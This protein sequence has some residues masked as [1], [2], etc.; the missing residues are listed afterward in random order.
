MNIKVNRS[1]KCQ[2]ST[3]TDTVSVISKIL[4]YRVAR[5]QENFHPGYFS[6]T[7]RKD[8]NEP[9][10]FRNC[11]KWY[12]SFTVKARIH[13][14]AHAILLSLLIIPLSPYQ[15][16]LYTL[17]QNSSLH[18]SYLRLHVPC[19]SHSQ[20]LQELSWFNS[21]YLLYWCPWDYF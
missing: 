1:L 8:L 4:V 7:A 10:N 12:L 5:S 16:L 20:H 6:K 15:S 9:K 3:D 14:G 13:H 11:K 18:H 2:L 21:T 17:Q 19:V